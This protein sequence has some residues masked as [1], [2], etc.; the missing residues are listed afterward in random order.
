L[1]VFIFYIARFVASVDVMA[2]KHAYGFNAD[3]EQVGLP[4]GFMRPD[5]D[6]PTDFRSLDTVAERP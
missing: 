3:G 4:A 2:L 1:F 5:D 6:A